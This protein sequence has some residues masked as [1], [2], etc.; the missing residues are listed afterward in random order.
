MLA[1]SI[2]HRAQADPPEAAA[3][4]RLVTL[5]L[6]L[7]AA[8]IGTSQ[9]I[10]GRAVDQLASTPN[11][12]RQRPTLVIEFAASPRDDSA[13]RGS[14]FADAVKLARF[15]QGPEVAA[16][17]TVAYLP[18]TVTGHAVLAALACDE[19][20][21]APEA[22]FGDAAADEAPERPVGPGM[23]S[24]YEEVA[25]NR[26]NVPT[27]VAASLV[28]A[29]TEVLRVETEDSIE[30]VPR[31]GVD[32]LRATKTIVA[33]EVLTPAGATALFSGRQAR[34][35]GFARFLA[36]NR[37]AL[38]RALQTTVDSLEEDQS[39]LADWRPVMID[40]QGPVTPRVKQR[41]SSL[42]GGEIDSAGV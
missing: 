16:V 36:P 41:I 21:I 30:F 7:Q 38:A 25:A 26:G 9:A 28:D 35:L 33:Q 23:V 31:D 39:L 40:L 34:E 5:R 8:D 20:A 42:I 4:V 6:P 15:L 27:A 22:E 14:T 2:P 24:I 12:G 3:P 17:K 37:A 11:E 18:R 1:A 29:Q 13:G 32:G 10:I 19:I